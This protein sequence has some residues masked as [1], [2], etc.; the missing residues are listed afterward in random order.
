VK[1]SAV[2][3]GFSFTLEGGGQFLEASQA[4]VH[5]GLPDRSVEQRAELA[6]GHLRIGQPGE[7]D[8]LE[9]AA[10]CGEV[11]WL[12]ALVALVRAAGTRATVDF[13]SGA[14]VSGATR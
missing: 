7:R 9:K 5:R 2:M 3:R 6:K 11:F 8:L 12:H 4:P 1:I 13:A 10:A 14:P